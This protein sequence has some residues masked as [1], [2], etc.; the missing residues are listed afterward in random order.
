MRSDP[1]LPGRALPV[2]AAIAT[3]ALVAGLVPALAGGDLM[4]EGRRIA[5]LAWGRMLLVDVYA[6]MALFAAWIAW[7]ERPAGAAAWIVALVA[8]G[9]LI[10]CLYVL[11]AW[12]RA[13]GDG[14]VFWHGRGRVARDAPRG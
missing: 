11:L 6:G 13:G 8:I 12:A 9:N 5:D 1:T 3:V 7:R 4:A 14:R 2:L 10:A